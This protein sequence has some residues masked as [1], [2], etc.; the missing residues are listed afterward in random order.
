[1]VDMYLF[2]IFYGG[3]II[4]LE[5]LISFWYSMMKVIIEMYMYC[6]EI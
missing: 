2:V 1:M 3:G 4:V 5:F 6:V